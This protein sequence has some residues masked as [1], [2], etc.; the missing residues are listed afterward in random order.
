MP[1]AT[2]RSTAQLD[3]FQVRGPGLVVLDS[4]YS[5]PASTVV[6][7]EVVFARVPTNARIN[8]LTRVYNDALGA[9]VTMS[10][11]LKAVSGNFT[12]SG[13]ALSTA[14]AVASANVVGFLPRTE[15]VSAGRMVWELL[16]L[17]SDPGGFADVIGVTAGATTTATAQD[18]T[19]A[20][21]YTVE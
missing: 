2:L 19:M 21:A 8:G 20:L 10:F 12:T 3:T 16:G 18:V 11:G 4:T 7:H 14:V 17:A 1:N 6:G 5:V 13:T 15:H 9:S